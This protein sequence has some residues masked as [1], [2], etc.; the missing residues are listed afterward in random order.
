M[1]NNKIMNSM[2]ELIDNSTPRVPVALC[3]DTSGSMCGQAIEDLQAG[4]LQ[5]KSELQ[6]DELTRYS[7]E[8]AVIS[9][10]SD[11]QCISDFCSIDDMEF[12]ELDADGY[13][14]MGAGLELAINRLEN[15]KAQ[16]R[17]A[18]VDY[19]QP[20][21][22]LM[23]D[24]YPNGD[25][26]VLNDAIDKIRNMQLSRKLTVVAVGVGSDV[27]F[28]VLERLCAKG[29]PIHLDKLHFREFFAWLSASVSGRSSSMPGME[30]PLDFSVLEE[31]ENED[32]KDSAL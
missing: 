29:K 5:Y 27:D 16:Y 28:S 26:K 32:W 3:L 30:E 23:T 21:L 19:Y 11:A 6:S 17:S 15:R 25:P 2:R 24:G 31:M 20:I 22:V 12:S 7:A 4:L 14:D 9:Y 13:T 10:N 18:G 1:K 8:T